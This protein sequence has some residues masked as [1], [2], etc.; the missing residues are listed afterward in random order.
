VS[1]LI[2]DKM[3]FTPSRLNAA[4]L[5]SRIVSGAI[6]G[7]TIYGVVKRP[8]SSAD[9][10]RLRGPLLVIT[11]GRGSAVRCLIWSCTSGRRFCDWRRRSHNRADGGQQ[12]AH[13]LAASPHFPAPSSAGSGQG[14]DGSGQPIS[15]VALDGLV[16]MHPAPILQC[17]VPSSH[18]AASRD[19]HSQ[20][21]L[22][23]QCQ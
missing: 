14:D 10:E 4:P 13:F 17:I 20:L 22:L 21:H 3:P 16:P 6:C 7:A 19:T 9:W 18:T 12:L 23:G 8:Q 11:C 2:A 1:E 5:P 15:V